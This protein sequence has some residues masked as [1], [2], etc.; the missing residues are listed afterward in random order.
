M[1]FFHKDE[2]VKANVSGSRPAAS[3]E[4]VNNN[5]GKFSAVIK[6]DG[7]FSE[8]FSKISV[9]ILAFVFLTSLIIGTTLSKYVTDENAHF[10]DDANIDYSVNSV[11]VV[12]T[13]DE[14]FEAINQGYTYVQLD[15]DIENP[16]I[17]TQKAETLDSDLILDLNG[18]EIQRNGYDPILNIK[19]GV[20]L[21]VVDTST[22]QT[23][24]LYNP[25]GS[26][27]NIIGGTLTIVTG[28]FESGP[29]YSE[30]YSYNNGVLNSDENSLT[31]R[32]TVEDTPQSVKFF[33]KNAAGTTFVQDTNVQKAPIIR[34]YPTKTGGIE[35]NHG[36]LYFDEQVTLGDVT[37]YPDTYCYYRTSEDTAKDATDVS[38]ADWCYTYVVTANDY[39]YVGNQIP[40]G[41][42]VSDY[43]EVTIYGYENVI[44]QAS[45]KPNASEYHAAI[46]MTSGVL[47]VQSGSFYQY[48]GVPTTA[49]VNSQG[50]EIN[51][52][53]GN[54][55]VRVPDA[56]HYTANQVA[57]KEDDEKAFGTSYFTNFKWCDD[58]DYH[59]ES[60]A[61]I[62]SRAKKGE[63]YCIL[64]GGA[65]K[66]TMGTGKAYAS[67]NN[68]ISMKNG[69]LT[70]SGGTFTKKMVN[71]SGSTDLA[72]NPKLSAISMDDGTL[73]VSNA[74]C[75][76]KGDGTAGILINAG[77][78][79][80]EASAFGVT[81]S[82]VSGIYSTINSNDGF[83]VK[84][85]AFT[86]TGENAVGIYSKNGR[87]NLSADKSPEI[88]ITGD[89]SYGIL[90]EAGGSVVS[91]N[92][93][94]EIVGAN[95]L[96]IRAEKTANGI[97]V[98]NGKMTI[99]GSGSFGIKSYFQTSDTVGLAS[100]D[101][102]GRFT[103]SDFSID[104][105]EDGTQSYS[106]QTGIYSENGTISLTSKSN[107]LISIDGTSAKG[108]HV[109]HG[110][111]V[112]SQGYS[113]AFGGD[114][115][116]GIYAEA[117]IV[118]L[119]GGSVNL[120]SNK[121]CYG[122]YA[123]SSTEILKILL[124]SV[125]VNVGYVNGTASAKSG[126]VA[127]SA[128]VFLSSSV[129]D[130]F[131]RLD[132]ATVKSFEVGVVSNG[133]SVTMTGEGEIATNM[134]S[135]VAIHG[136]NVTFEKDSKYTLTSK[137]TTTAGGNN[138]YTMT[139][140][141]R[142]GNMLSATEY[143][144][145]DG[146]YVNGGSFTSYGDLTV[147]HTGLRNSTS[148]P[149]RN[150]YNYNSLVVTSYAVRVLG[151]DVNIEQAKITAVIG[152]GVYAGKTSVSG[153]EQTGNITL[154]KD[155]V[156]DKTITVE[157]K[158]ALVGDVYNAIGRSIS[159]GWKSY[160]SITGGHA[161]EL[162]GGDITVYYG[163]YTAQF[164]N[165]VY[166]NGNGEI[167]VYGGT[168]NGYMK[169]HEA[170]GSTSY[171][172][173]NGKSG[174]SAYYGLKVVGGANVNIYD[175]V[176]D[177]GNG[178][179]FV[180]GVT[181]LTMSNNTTSIRSSATAHVY[182]YKGTFGHEA[183]SGTG[184]AS[185]DSFNV[186]DDAIVVFGAGG[187]DYFGSNTTIGTYKNA[188]ALHANNAPIAVNAMT[189]NQNSVI[190]SEIYVYYGTYNC[191]GNGKT[192]AT[193]LDN[194]VSNSGRGTFYKTYN[195]SLG[196][197]ATYLASH[198]MH[199]D[200]KNTTVVFYNG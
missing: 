96:G 72:A 98:S 112:A 138:V 78:L 198:T 89:D 148:D 63:S 152:G 74:N 117:G 176:F 195:K 58:I 79:S 114:N 25:V 129:A 54:F 161:I 179:G 18:I 5:G 7:K 44:K 86:I 102:E 145:T 71:Y 146:V 180:T 70:V 38:M 174:P 17:V 88:I 183:V 39:S 101:I 57:V 193:Y 160:K 61:F 115:S 73:K 134:A 105:P 170:I 94:Y 151:G 59:D 123:E 165:G 154:G 27:F 19:G 52:K 121:T 83:K 159:D 107:S 15:K 6:N 140:P 169:R 13:Q 144:N 133:G 77:T 175:G 21:T 22:E 119:S 75:D 194:F 120:S 131:V 130:S 185:E 110:G 137:N 4:K 162:N 81:G 178:G 189:Q 85:T 166:A 167:K 95:A 55:S 200:E 113:Y 91:D 9:F 64:N 157:T 147:E 68:V 164:G 125:T 46:Q 1:T 191:Y 50:G 153:V 92:Y 45:D 32:T 100:D 29:R 37:V 30:Y 69:S 47:D 65:A 41:A 80:V 188:I 186:Y 28:T 172:N 33:R 103:V 156:S 184:N 36:N 171:T 190:K 139:L 3:N 132:G 168:F 56:T 192:E 177:G 82:A 155:G 199:G 42:N 111:S 16:L 106:D 187:S 104:M 136:G 35:Y 122:V 108:I 84:D 2:K 24:G 149:N 11:F 67:N 99:K 60:G 14:L 158:G 163:T 34:S 10:G 97:K 66:V 90:V 143:A 182:I 118:S 109:G 23:G 8:N 150:T 43:V 51:V 48:F 20:R 116:Y 26:V 127:A 76:V 49:C 31:K 93:D 124:Q 196:Y 181:E 128:G 141:V 87:V 62:G 173:I 40:A 53:Q 142:Q 197:V 126:T 12:K 135:S